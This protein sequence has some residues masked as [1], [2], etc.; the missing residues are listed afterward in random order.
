MKTRR[1]W[2]GLVFFA[3]LTGCTRQGNIY[4]LATGERTTL[5]YTVAGTGRGTIKGTF[6]SGETASG[7]YAVVSSASIGWGSIYSSV[8]TR[9][10]QATANSNAISMSQ[11]GR[12]FGSAILTGSRGAVITCEFALGSSGHGYGACS[13]QDNS[14][15]KLM[16]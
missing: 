11:N 7:E 13:G 9:T 10:G 16:F 4:N 8:Y 2:G 1:L 12:R 3:L 15:Y 6:A 14:T 5:I